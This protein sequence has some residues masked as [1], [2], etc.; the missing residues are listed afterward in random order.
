MALRY[1]LHLTSE[2]W[3][4][5][6]G[7][8]PLGMLTRCSWE[9]AWNLNSQVIVDAIK[10]FFFFI[11]GLRHDMSSWMFNAWPWL[12][13][14]VCVCE[15]FNIKPVPI[16]PWV[17][18]GQK[19]Y[20]WQDINYSYL[21]CI[22]PETVF[23]PLWLHLYVDHLMKGWEWWAICLIVGTRISHI[24]LP[25]VPI[26]MPRDQ[27]LFLIWCFNRLFL[28]TDNYQEYILLILTLL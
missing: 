8:L 22:D 9:A 19:F 5:L 10:F 4:S 27:Q 24:D 6:V 11:L 21:Y 23:S 15:R 20:G 7:W 25:R 2:F 16:E 12:L 3:C 28:S 26:F 1:C 18:W 13:L 17:I 14:W